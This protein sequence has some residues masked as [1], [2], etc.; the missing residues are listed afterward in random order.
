MLVPGIILA[1]ACVVFFVLIIVDSGFS[2]PQQFCWPLAGLLLIWI[3]FLRPCVQL[4]QAGVVMRN[5]VRDVRAGWP[6]LD[7]VEQRWNL[8]IYNAAGKGYG[9]WAITSQ[10]PR[11][12]NRRTG[13]H[14][15]PGIGEIDLEDPTGSVMGARPGSA[16]G[17]AA[18]IRTGQ[19]DY[20][21]AVGRDPSVRA[22]DEF[23]VEPAW[24]PIAALVLAVILVVV[25]L[26][27]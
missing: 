7:L 13:M 2:K 10:R 25:A 4:S 21:G 22:K 11:R 19:E 16:A 17:V 26:V 1:V 24:A 8:K 5:L 27:A 23:V 14:A 15:G 6:A 3:V 9:S 12:V 18:A 20:E